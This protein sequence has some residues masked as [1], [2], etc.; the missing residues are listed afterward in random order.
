M[1]EWAWQR[2]FD[3]N[4]KSAFFMSQLVGRVMADENRERG[5]LVINVGAVDSPDTS[6]TGYAAY[7]A[8]KAALAAFTKECA[9]EFAPFD[10]AV[11][12]IQ[13]ASTSDRQAD[14]NSELFDKSGVVEEIAGAVLRLSC[15]RDTQ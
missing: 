2:C 1:D 8:S 12:I 11:H 3:V 4:L 13:P 14:P 6:T 7:V 15:A 9:R 10:V 5:G